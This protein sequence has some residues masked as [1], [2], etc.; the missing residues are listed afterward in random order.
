[1]IHDMHRYMEL[2][3]EGG[4][5]IDVMEKIKEVRKSHRKPM[6]L[7]KRAVVPYSRERGRQ[8][9]FSDTVSEGGASSAEENEEEDEEEEDEEE[10][11]EEEEEEWGEDKTASLKGAVWRLVRAF[12]RGTTKEDPYPLQHFF[13]NDFIEWHQTKKGFEGVDPR[14]IN[15]LMGRFDD[16]F[17]KEDTDK[18]GVSVW[19]EKIW[20]EEEVERNRR[21][22]Q[23]SICDMVVTFIKD[24]TYEKP[25]VGQLFSLAQLQAWAKNKY[26]ELY[27]TTAEVN[28]ATDETSPASLLFTFLAILTSL[29]FI[30]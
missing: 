7:E 24:T 2:Y 11:D 16:I 21:L 14:W 6:L 28:I 4:S 27:E 10:E 13:F 8:L 3:K 25:Y 17:S 23:E 1:M 5:A 19:I 22:A 15:Y 18:E 29:S 9:N 30:T 20:D 12:I 26:W